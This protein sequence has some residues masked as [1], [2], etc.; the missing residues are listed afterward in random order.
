MAMTKHYTKGG[1]HLYNP[2]DMEMFCDHHAPGLFQ[3]MFKSILNES[4]AVPSAKRMELQKIR[5]VVM[6]HNLTF[7]RNQVFFY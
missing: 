7:Y 5:T 4:K 3:Q 1:R 2:K 6:L